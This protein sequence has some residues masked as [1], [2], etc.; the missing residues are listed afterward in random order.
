MLAWNGVFTVA[1]KRLCVLTNLDICACNAWVE[2]NMF[3]FFL[4][5]SNYSFQLQNSLLFAFFPTDYELGFLKLADFCLLQTEALDSANKLV[6]PSC[7][8]VVHIFKN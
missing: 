1:N 3:G 6:S 5:K 7:S 4:K 8:L 2:G